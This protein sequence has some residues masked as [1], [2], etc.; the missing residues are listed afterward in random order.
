LS[1]WTHATPTSQPG[2]ALQCGA[3]SSSPTVRQPAAMMTIKTTRRG[4]R[5]PEATVVP[6][7]R[8]GGSSATDATV[9]DNRRAEFVVKACRILDWRRSRYAYFPSAMFGEPAWDML[10]ALYCREAW[11]LHALAS[12]AGTPPGI[13]RRWLA[14][15][16]DER[17][18]IVDDDANDP[19]VRLSDE[20][21]ARLE[22]F[23]SAEPNNP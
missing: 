5:A 9:P 13:A 16:K 10:L 22:D 17:L 2:L 21:T 19:K 14:Y 8:S 23:L 18:V 12:R 3:R 1:D 20:G 4:H 11:T 6:F 15:M 7:A